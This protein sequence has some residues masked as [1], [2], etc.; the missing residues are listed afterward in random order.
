MRIQ[1]K[2]TETFLVNELLKVIEKLQSITK[3]DDYKP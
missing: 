1:F 3:N 2:H